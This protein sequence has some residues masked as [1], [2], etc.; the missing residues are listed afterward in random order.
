MVDSSQV[1]KIVELAEVQ[2]GDN[3]LEIG[4]GLGSLTL[5]LLDS[6]AK[7]TAVELDKRLGEL[8]PQTV[9]TLAP[10]VAANLTVFVEDAL[11]FV[12]PLSGTYK[13][14]ANLPYNVG[15][16]ILLTLLERYPQISSGLILVQ[17]EVAERLVA[18]PGSKT[19]GIPSLKLAWFAKSYIPT[20]VPRSA[21]FPV[22]RVDSK[23][24]QFSRHT[25]TPDWQTGVDRSEVFS[26]INLGLSQRRKTLKSLLV[27]DGK[28]PN[29]VYEALDSL[30]I[31]PLAR[32]E[33]LS[34][35]DFAELTKIV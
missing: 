8:L 31:D 27:A 10:E 19:Y 9:K 2:E 16:P 3:V 33:T 7:V 15:V 13:L 23:L 25:T 14:V 26:L 28:T 17:S 24:V 22:P 32:A 6:G 12:E 5:G 34:I 20:T 21:F 30:Q 11:K 29:E 4:P 35:R 1:R 18:E